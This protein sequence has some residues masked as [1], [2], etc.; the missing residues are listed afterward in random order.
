MNEREVGGERPVAGAKRVPIPRLALS[1]QEAA[2]ALGVSVNFFEAEIAPELPMIR[3]GRR[4]LI[5]VRA[6][7]RWLEQQADLAGGFRE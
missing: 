2:Q 6:V 1:K 5:A 7:E 4:R 3:R